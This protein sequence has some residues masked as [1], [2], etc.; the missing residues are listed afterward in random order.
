MKEMEKKLSEMEFD[1]VGTVKEIAEDLRKQVAGMGI[2]EGKNIRMATKQP[3]KG[4]VV[5]EVDE[6]FTSLGLGVAE[7]IVVEM[8]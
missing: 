2:R 4:P 8:G 5:V 7:K 3:I 6:S 1:E